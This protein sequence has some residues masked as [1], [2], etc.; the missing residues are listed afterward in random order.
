M[1][2]PEMPGAVFLDL[3]VGSGAVGL[4]A[5]SRGAKSAT[6]VEANRKHALALVNQAKHG[7]ISKKRM[8][9]TASLDPDL[10][11][12]ILFPGQKK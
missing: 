4:E 11:L 5:I 2:A 1:L 10:L 8:M 7:R 3:F 6:F 12:D 9:F